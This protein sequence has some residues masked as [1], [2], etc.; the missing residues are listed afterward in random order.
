MTKPD[1]FPHN[2]DDDTEQAEVENGRF[3]PPPLIPTVNLPRTTAQKE[4][5]LLV[6]RS[7]PAIIVSLLAFAL[8]SLLQFGPRRDCCLVAA[9]VDAHPPLAQAGCIAYIGA[10]D[11]QIPCSPM[12]KTSANLPT[13]ASRSNSPPGITWGSKWRSSAAAAS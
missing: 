13:N 12:A 7:R 6:C 11:S 9:L 8:V 2:L 3:F 5:W 4:A 1:H 10:Q